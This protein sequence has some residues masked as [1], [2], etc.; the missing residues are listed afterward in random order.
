MSRTV[1]VQLG[2]A[3]LVFCAALGA[4]VWGLGVL[5]AQGMKL[6]E[7]RTI[8]AERTARESG[9]IELERTAAASAPAREMLAR[10]FL[11]DEEE[12]INYLNEIEA[13][14]ADYRVDFTTTNLTA[15]AEE[16]VGASHLLVDFS[17]QGTRADVLRYLAVLESLPY[18]SRLQSVRLENASP[19]R[20]EAT[21]TIK[22]FIIAI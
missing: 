10:Y 22:V 14:A 16:V 6:D 17:M 11:R 12:S 13:L 2:V 15:Q 19:G 9:F 4:F 3:S 8:L 20:F 5:E 7:Q 21:A 1:L 18:L